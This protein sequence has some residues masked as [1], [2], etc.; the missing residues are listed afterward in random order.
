MDRKDLSGLQMA[1]LMANRT[2][3]LI[4]DLQL[5]LILQNSLKAKERYKLISE[6]GTFVP[7]GSQID[8]MDAAIKAKGL[9]AVNSELLK[10][11][12]SLRLKKDQ[13][14]RALIKKFYRP[15]TEKMLTIFESNDSHM[16][17]SMTIGNYFDMLQDNFLQ[18]CS[19]SGTRWLVP[20]LFKFYFQLLNQ[21]DKNYICEHDIFVMIQELD[22]GAPAPKSKRNIA[23]SAE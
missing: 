18:K 2:G 20:R 8:N 15:L 4:M 21:G 23:A 6:S 1:T 9:Q 11:L 10:K 7:F 13:L 19:V 14:K 12:Q 5:P 3:V 17:N 16:S 22:G